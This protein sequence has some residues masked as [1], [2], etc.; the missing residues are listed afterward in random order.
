MSSVTRFIRQVPTGTNFVGDAST[1][2]QNA[3]D[4]VPT[5]GNY[6]GNYPPGYVTAA[7]NT[8]LAATLAAADASAGTAVVRD[9]G[10]TI[11]APVSSLTGNLG[12]FREYQLLKV[13]PIN[14]AQG[15]LGGPSGSTFGVV[16]QGPIS[17]SP[18]SY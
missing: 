4:F 9:M 18:L 11:Y 12:Y 10:K 16:G 6:V 8:S 7:A 2:I 3:Y 1:L 14:A 17:P 15:F 5:N 13:N